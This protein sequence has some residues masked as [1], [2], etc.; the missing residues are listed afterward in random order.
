VILDDVTETI[1]VTLAAGYG[2]RLHKA[3]RKQP[4]QRRFQAY[5]SFSRGV[6]IEEGFT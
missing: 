3:W 2:G 1:V 6:E 4:G 5:D